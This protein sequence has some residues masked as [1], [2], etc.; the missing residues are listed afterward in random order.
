MKKILI[1]IIVLS[2][3]LSSCSFNNEQGGD[4]I[5]VIATS[6]VAYDFLREIGGDKIDLSLLVKPGVE[7]HSYEP[8]PKDIIAIHNSDLFVYIGGKSDYWVNTLL[9]SENAPK[10]T[11]AMTDCVTLLDSNPEHSHIH[12]D[13][14]EHV[15][16]SPKNSILIC[17]KIAEVLCRIDG[18]NSNFYT[19]NLK[20]YTN[21]LSILD[22]GFKNVVAEGKRD[23]IIFGDRFPI[24]Y[25]THEYGLNYH[26]AY[27]GCSAEAEP[28]ASTIAFLIE[29]VKTERIPVVFHIELSNEDIADTIVSATGAKKRLF[30]SCH[31]ISAKDFDSG[32]SYIDLM[33]KNL[34]SLKEALN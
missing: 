3:I 6:F 14:D 24:V 7:L 5:S 12:K 23:T 21:E 13:L 8:S 34:I 29:K 28:S 1:F 25:F 16:T 26:A 17:Q 31:N 20:K 15:W 18:D 9:S 22:N 11:L 33:K 32:I 19:L 4:K 30:Y 2:M 27:P 10:N